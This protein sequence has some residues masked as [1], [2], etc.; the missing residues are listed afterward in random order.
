MGRGVFSAYKN[1]QEGFLAAIFAFAVG[2]KAQAGADR[3]SQ[4]SE[5]LILGA[6]D[7]NDRLSPI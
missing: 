7:I 5:L 1:T 2:L 4:L 3:L 6:I